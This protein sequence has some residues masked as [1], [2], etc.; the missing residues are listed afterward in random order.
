MGLVSHLHCFCKERRAAEWCFCRV[1]RGSAPH[2]GKASLTTVRAAEW[3]CWSN[4]E[5]A[6]QVPEEE[7]HEIGQ[8]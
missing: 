7:Q 2:L 3:R 8:Q 1:V 6:E 5:G 4:Q